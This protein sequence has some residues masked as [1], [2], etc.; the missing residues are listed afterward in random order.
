MT[1]CV[2]MDDEW[3]SEMVEIHLLAIV[4]IVQCSF[5]Y[6]VSYFVFHDS[7]NILIRKYFFIIILCEFYIFII[8]NLYNVEERMITFIFGELMKRDKFWILK[9]LIEKH[10]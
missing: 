7:N 1:K 4:V 2:V 10:E 9:D 3:L 8:S 6:C 5:V